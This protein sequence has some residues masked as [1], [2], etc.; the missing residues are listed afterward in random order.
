M[1]MKP[2][3]LCAFLAALALPCIAQAQTMPQVWGP[4]GQYRG[5]VERNGNLYTPDGRY[6]GQI[7]RN[8]GLPRAS[9]GGLGRT[10]NEQGHAQR[11]SDRNQSVYGANGQYL[12]QVDRKGQFYD[13]KGIYRGELVR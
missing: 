6:M 8:P 2:V 10:L 5:S 11:Q 1:P 4:T 13:T 9:E 12:G 3:V 7:Q